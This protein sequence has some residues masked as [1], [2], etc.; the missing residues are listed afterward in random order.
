[1]A[2]HATQVRLRKCLKTAEYVNPVLH[3][4]QSTLCTVFSLSLL[5]LLLLCSIR[6]L[7]KCPSP[8]ARFISFFFCFV[9]VT[10][11]TSI[12]VMYGGEEIVYAAII[13]LD[14]SLATMQF[15]VD[16][17]FIRI[18]IVSPASAESVYTIYQLC[19]WST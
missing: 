3:N 14:E 16:A 18:K 4:S 6:S 15:S 12:T 2:L 13:Y 10:L 1:M 7:P 11:S 17:P 9:L 19:A 5:S 8:C